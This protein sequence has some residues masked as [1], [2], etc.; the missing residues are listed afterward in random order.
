MRGL[1]Y[2]RGMTRFRVTGITINDLKRTS[3]VFTL[4]QDEAPKSYGHQHDHTVAYN[5]GALRTE[6]LD[7]WIRQATP[8]E[9][10]KWNAR[11]LVS[12][13]KQSECT[14]NSTGVVSLEVIDSQCAR[15]V[16]CIDVFSNI[17]GHIR[18]T[19]IKFEKFPSSSSALWE[20]TDMSSL[21]RV[22]IRLSVPARYYLYVN[23]VILHELGHA[24][25]L[26][27][28]RSPTTYRGIMRQD[29][30]VPYMTTRDKDLLEKIYE[31]HTPGEGW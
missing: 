1:E 25:G 15:G 8:G 21:H 20:W 11:P 5:L 18:D 12:V 13:C 23:A 26:P 29:L 9:A 17:K 2:S 31:S 22:M 24:L 10:S 4:V 28:F 3:A 7:N 14:T 30:S 6:E 19:S 27:D 16:A